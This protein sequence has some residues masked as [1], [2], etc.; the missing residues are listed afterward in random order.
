MTD[1]SPFPRSLAELSHEPDVPQRVYL[2][3]AAVFVTSLLLA[4][5]LCVKLFL[6]HVELPGLGTVPVEH[7]AG[8]LAFPVTFLLTDLLNEYY[9]RRGARRVALLAFAM[10]VLALLLISAARWLPIREG[11]PGTAT[12]SAF[13]QIFG[14][15]Q[16]MY[17]ASLVAFLLGSFLDIALFGFFKRLTRGRLVWLRATGSTVISQVFD[18]LVVT[19]LFFRT[20]PQMLGLDVAEPGFVLRTAAT[21]YLLKFALAIALTPVIYAGRAVLARAFGLVPLPPERA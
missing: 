11:V 13:E 21:G 5:I 14:S 2:W 10:A 1:P 6:F 7:T 9:G 15:S 20:F 8:M 18:S 4:N 17:V 16:V 3:L 19:W 12:A